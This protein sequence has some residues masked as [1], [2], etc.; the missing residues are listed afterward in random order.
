MQNEFDDLTFFND[1]VED[2]T[3][4]VAV[5]AQLLASSVSAK[6]IAQGYHWN[7]RGRDF[8]EFHEFFQELYE[9]F[10]S[11]VDP[12]AEN[13]RKLGVQTPYLLTDLLL[14]SQVHETEITTGEVEP[15]LASLVRVNAT[16]LEGNR[17]AFDIANELN[18]QGIANFLAERIDMHQ[19]WNWQLTSTLGL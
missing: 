2:R 16:L 13:I 7:V 6:T 9:D 12:L 18:E 14:L 5:L 11:A 3:P 4:L 17:K 19:K 8:R 10:D 1:P 15:M